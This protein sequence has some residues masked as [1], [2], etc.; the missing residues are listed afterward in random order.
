MRVARP[1]VTDLGVNL[2]PMID[3]VFQLIIF[4][5]VAS[6][7]A[8]QENQVTLELPQAETGHDPQPTDSRRLVVNVTRSGEL[9]LA[10]SGLSLEEFSQRVAFERQRRGDDLEIRIRAD[11]GV[12]YGVVEPIMTRCARA[13]VWRVSFAVLRSR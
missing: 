7:L 10:G 11:R 4:F 9:S 1:S 13:G 3:I 6:H 5:L 2:T 12:P 8:Q